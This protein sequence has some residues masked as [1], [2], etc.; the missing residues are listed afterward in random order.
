MATGDIRVTVVDVG[1]GQCTFVEIYDNSSTPVL[2]HTL[3]FDCGSDKTSDNTY[4][5]LDYIATKAIQKKPPGLDAIFFSHSDKDH[6]S[7]THYVLD[8]IKKAEPTSKVNQVWYGGSKENF[9]KYNFNILKYIY[10]AG[11]CT[12][13]NIKGFNTNS[14]DY[15]KSKKGFEHFMWR[16]TNQDVYVRGLVANVISDD[17]DWDDTTDDFTTKTAEEKNRVSL[18]ACL[19]YAD[20]SYVICGDATN[21]T[22]SAVNGLL[23]DGTTTFDNNIMTTMPHHGSRATGLAVKS[24]A[25]ASVTSVNV[26]DT[27][28]TLMKSISMTISAYEKHRHPSLELI[29][30]FIPTKKTPLLR[31]PRLV[32]KN[33][34]RISAYVDID[35]TTGTSVLIFRGA[36]Y[37]FESETNT[38]STRYSDLGPYFA[39]NLGTTQAQASQGVVVTKP[40]TAINPFACWRYI[41]NAAK[42]TTLAGLSSMAIPLMRFTENALTNLGA[43]AL[44]APVITADVTESLIEIMPESF[45]TFRIKTKNQAQKIQVVANA[46]IQNKL[47]HYY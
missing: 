19:F 22:M 45:P 39:Y 40:L 30:R 33:T 14:T 4:T 9:T 44:E 31:D 34:H 10:D 1:Q 38:F 21:K 8:K 16:N 6:I 24:G 3:L 41:T 43:R 29:N 28:A 47:K 42:D 36:P 2:L 17:P 27:F 15:T 37:T 13:A 12:S 26:V 46:S 5:N 23:S 7:L 18:I 35:I 25:Q 11:F 20:A 32:Q